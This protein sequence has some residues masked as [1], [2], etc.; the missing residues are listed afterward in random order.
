[1]NPYERNAIDFLAK[2]D[3]LAKRKDLKTKDSLFK[4]L[5]H[6]QLR[7]GFHLGLKVAGKVGMGDES[8]FYCYYGKEDPILSGLPLSS[9]DHTLDAILFA[10]LDVEPSEMGAWQAYLLWMSPTV[11]PVFWHGGYIVREYF[12]D[13]ENFKGI[14]PTYGAMPV[15]V[16]LDKI[17]QPTV[18]MEENK[19]VVSCPYWNEWEGLVLESMPIIFKGDGEIAFRRA[20]HKVLYKYNCGICF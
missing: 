15:N 10:G 8:S 11:L 3:Y 18:T 9:H 16:T 6:I 20:K 12:F 2:I 17:P 1:M 5:V 4:V 19:A 7:E 13:R 14:I